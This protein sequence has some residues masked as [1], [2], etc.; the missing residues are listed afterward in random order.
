M[1]F[2]DKGLEKQGREMTYTDLHI[3]PTSGVVL[4]PPGPR[5]LRTT[6]ETTPIRSSTVRQ[7]NTSRPARNS[8]RADII[9]FRVVDGEQEI[10]DNNAHV[11]NR[12]NR[13]YILCNH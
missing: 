7:T 4:C 9:F 6:T 1:C 12:N 10:F 13:D 11:I 8:P 5:R 2:H 3:P